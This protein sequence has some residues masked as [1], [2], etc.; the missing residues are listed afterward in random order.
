LDSQSLFSAFFIMTLHV[1]QVL[2]KEL[3][4]RGIDSTTGVYG[5]HKLQIG[6]GKPIALDKIASNPVPREGFGTV[7][8]IQRG[9]AGLETSAKDTLK[10]LASQK[11]DAKGILGSLMAAKTHLGRMDRLGQLTEEQKANTMWL[12]TKAVESLSNEEL[13]RVYQT[14]SSREMD[15]MQS[16]LARESQINSNALDAAFAS[17]AL[18]DLSA[19]VIKEVSNRAMLCQID[20]AMGK[21]QDQAEREGLELMKPQSLSQTWGGLEQP[22]AQPA[23][24]LQQMDMT[25]MNL[26]TLVEVASTSATQREKNALGQAQRLANRGVDGVTVKQMGDVL[27]N[28]ELTIN[29]P[30]DVLFKDTF[31]LKK[32]NQPILNIFQLKDKGM[33]TKSDEYIALRDTAEKK[34][35]PEFEGRERK[36]GERP[37]YG[38]LN[39]KQHEKGAAADMEYGNVCIVLKD[40][41]KKR[42]TYSSGDTFYAP[43]LTITPERKANFYKLLDG[44][45]INPMSA[46][47]LRDP[48]SAEHKKCELILDRLALNPE[49][50]TTAFKTGRKGTGLSLPDDEDTK[51]R[52]L[53]FQCFV[54]SD[55]VRE[56]MATYDNLESLVTGLDDIDGNMLANAAKKEQPGQK[57][58]NP[59]QLGAGKYIEAQIHGPVVPSRDIAEI[60][61]D[62]SELE[63]LYPTEEELENARE[64]LKA[65]TRETGIPVTITHY[66]D[67]FD[68]LLSDIDYQ[69]EKFSDTHI[70]KAASQAELNHMLDNLD[71][72]LRLHNGSAGKVPVSNLQFSDEDKA[73]IRQIAGEQLQEQ[74]AQPTGSARSHAIAS[75]AFDAAVQ[76]VANE[77]VEQLKTEAAALQNEK[78]A[79]IGDAIRDF[80]ARHPEVTGGHDFTVSGAAQQELVKQFRMNVTTAINSSHHPNADVPGLVQNALD[81]AISKMIEQKKPLLDTLEDIQPAN[82]KIKDIARNLI[83]SDNSGLTP[84]R[85]RVLLQSA[86]FRSEMLRE[87]AAAKPPMSQ[88]KIAEMLKQITQHME[89]AARTIEDPTLS[90]A[91]AV[92]KSAELALALLDAFEPPASLQTIRAL[93]DQLDSEPM[94]Q[95]IG[96]YK[97]VAA[98]AEDPAQAK[99][100][101]VYVD[102]LE[103]LCEGLC[104]KAREMDIAEKSAQ[105]AGLPENEQEQARANL[106]TSDRLYS[107]PA[108][109]VGTVSMITPG[110]RSDIATLAPELAESLNVRF[111]ALEAFPAPASPEALPQNHAQRKAFLVN[112]LDS[113]LGHEKTFER[114]T[115]VH[116]RGHISRAFIFATVMSN[117]L[118]A[119]G[120]KVDKNAVLLG[121]AGHDIGRKGGNK[122]RW[123][124]RSADMTVDLMRQDYGANSMGQAYEQEVG[125]C[126]NGHQSKT[127]EGMLLN[128]ADSLDI[129]RTKDFDP[130]YFDFLKD[131]G[132]PEAEQIRQDLIKE[133]TLLQRLTDYKCMNMKLL[134]KLWE[135]AI[136]EN[137]P[138]AVQNE[139]SE[140]ANQLTTEIGNQFIADWE[141]PSD[142]YFARYEDVIKNNPDLFPTLNKYYFAEEA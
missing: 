139:M 134:G 34:V 48:N 95:T 49:S 20:E 77:K 73:K 91:D 76:R 42:S 1:D 99:M 27:R 84:D 80:A 11:F 23:Q 97:R 81:D 32:P 15:L 61:V 70:D 92:R 111:R 127:V 66:D 86:M 59:V 101:N 88:Q 71:E 94:R 121:I 44:C 46:A 100:L 68:Q 136:D 8:Q 47:L 39:L 105:I 140:Q 131:S 106:Q 109:F 53:L 112:H 83:L 123:E 31:L 16:A 142:E 115:S 122:D 110:Q 102:G 55:S 72:E 12:F 54:D 26:M 25:A 58:K 7:S 69:N 125:K 51:L 3:Q 37:A 137:L 5:D 78:I 56:N 104:N 4:S 79:S 126:I 10:S 82:G 107:A 9:K 40:S 21:T 135:D 117:I 138:Q 67:K 24:P 89:L 35:F 103:A 120:V 128:S 129:G 108:P 87:M 64:E 96:L 29:V 90:S 130:Q 75:A 85:F 33:S 45:G 41:V 38:A 93:R 74:F 14:F 98:L 43:K 30:V 65:F 141:V 119:K 113:Y 50:D 133:A 6:N 13:A 114:G 18:F 124:Q 52:A 28:A 118:I 63:S 22:A 19:L 2:S 116:G 17:E 36:S 60:R 132:V 57:Q 62:I